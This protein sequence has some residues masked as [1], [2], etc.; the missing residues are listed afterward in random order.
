MSV[1]THD[2]PHDEALAVAVRAAR[3]AAE[4]IRDQ[5]GRVEQVR[6]KARN[7]FVTATDEAAQ[8]AIVDVLRRESPGEALLAEEGAAPDAGPE[9]VEGRRWIVDPLDGTTNFMQQVPPYAVSIALQDEDAIV[10][11]AVLDVPHDELFTAVAGHGLQ[12]DG[13][14]VA[15]SRTDAFDEA[16]VATGFPYRSYDHLDTY[17]DVLDRVIREGRNVRRHGSAAVDLAWLAVGR[18][19]GFFETGLSPWDV[20]AGTLLV[21]EGGGR[22]T[23]YHADGGLAPLFGRQVCATNGALHNALL[24]R[25]A[26]MQDVR[27]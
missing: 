21:R 19:D 7:D 18:F 12:L 8:E 9:A 26:P 27:Q 22:V 13:T 3:R 6:A 10:L 11:G 14:P 16:V 24:D 1:P 20:A 15:C 23:D 17:L 25:V 4:L 2:S 5:T